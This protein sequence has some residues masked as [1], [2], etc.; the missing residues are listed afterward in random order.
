MYKRRREENALYKQFN[1][2]R[3]QLSNRTRKALNIAHTSAEA[4]MKQWPAKRHPALQAMY[5]P[6]HLTV[7]GPDGYVTLN[8]NRNHDPTLT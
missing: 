7:T 3:L 6:P 8:V 5:R 1:Y 2:E 4:A